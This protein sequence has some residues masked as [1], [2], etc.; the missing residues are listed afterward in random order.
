MNN[1]QLIERLPKAELHLHIEGTLEPDLMFELSKKN[2]VQIPFK[3][4]EDIQAAYQFTNLQSFLDI[5]FQGTNVLLKTQDFYDLTWAYL[6]KAKKDNVTHCEIFFDPQT[7]TNR[8]IPFEVVIEGIH[9]ALEDAK[10]KLNI[11]SHLILSFLRDLT[12]ESAFETLNQAMPYKDWIIGVGLDSAEVGHPPSKFKRV[13]EKAI[14]EGFI[15]VA[16]A[17]E[18][19]PAEYIWEAIKD[20]HVKRIDHGI[21]S[22]EDPKLIDYLKETQIPLTV[23]PLSNVKLRTFDTITDHNIVTLMRQGLLVMINSDDP[24]YFG[25]YVNDNYIAVADAFNLNASDIVQL[26]K[27]SFKASFIDDKAKNAAF[28]QIDSITDEFLKA[29]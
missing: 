6:E 2:N 21:R 16:H 14:S 22:I 20:L 5:Y 24:S 1:Q 4:V 3:S 29:S 17:G 15:P 9:Q 25:G 19:G 10:E 11:S 8:N 26:A 28:T 27:N 12:E 7:H 13:Y 23:C 18:E